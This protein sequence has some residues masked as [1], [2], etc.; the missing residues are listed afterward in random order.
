[1]PVYKSDINN[2]ITN[3]VSLPHSRGINDQRFCELIL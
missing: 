3:Y 2:V 1:V